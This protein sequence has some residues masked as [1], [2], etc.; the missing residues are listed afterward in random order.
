MDESDGTGSDVSASTRPKL[1]APEAF[2]H[3]SKDSPRPESNASNVS[4]GTVVSA[5]DASHNS[6]DDSV[7]SSVTSKL[8]E[9]TKSSIQE[10]ASQNFYSQAS[11]VLTPTSLPLPGTPPFSVAPD[12]TAVP[13]P[14]FK[15]SPV[16]PMINDKVPKQ[17]PGGTLEGL[18]KSIDDEVPGEE[19][20]QDS[21]SE[22]RAATP[23]A[24][25][26]VE[27]TEQVEG[28]SPASVGKDPI[29]VTEMSK[30]ESSES[31]GKVLKLL[32][33]SLLFS[34]LL[35]SALLFSAPLCL[36]SASSLLS[37]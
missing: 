32:F 16:S 4:S 31:D 3:S 33:S 5:L 19:T 13:I 24:E 25:I 2:T 30:S 8:S 37:S 22:D 27:E 34:A 10:A 6:V 12:P 21:E 35:F 36:L 9:S 18:G 7:M 1:I 20:E 15:S 26:M 14:N 17:S 28:R 23:V 11:G 29:A